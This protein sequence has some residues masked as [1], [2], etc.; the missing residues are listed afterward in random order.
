MELKTYQ[1]CAL[2]AFARW[3]EALKE[4]QDQSEIA[5]EAWPKAAGEIPVAVRNY[6][7]TAWETLRVAGGVAESAGEYV[8]RTGRRETPDSAYLLQSADWWR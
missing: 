8:D 7:K 5:I 1:V 4:A 6:P 2:E 3:Q